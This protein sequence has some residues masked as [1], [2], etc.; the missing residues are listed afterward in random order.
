MRL[1][2]RDGDSRPFNPNSALFATSSGFA[3]VF[4]EGV[5]NLPTGL[6]GLGAF[7]RLVNYMKEIRYDKID[8]H[9]SG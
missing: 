4:G 2:S 3:G 7:S 9:L 8:I 6:F 5:S 1:R